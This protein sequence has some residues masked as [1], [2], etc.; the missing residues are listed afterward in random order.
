MDIECC[1]IIVLPSVN[2][3][4]IAIVSLCRRID[5]AEEKLNA[6]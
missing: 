4:D 6:F 2:E 3:K 1:R 5:W